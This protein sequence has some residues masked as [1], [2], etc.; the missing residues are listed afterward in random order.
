MDSAEFKQ[1][2]LP[3]HPLFFRIARNMLE[4]PDDAADAVQELYLRLCREEERLSRC[5]NPEGYGIRILQHLCTDR[6]RARKRQPQSLEA[7][8]QVGRIPEAA[9]PDGLS[10]SISRETLARL[11]QCI[12]ELPPRQRTVLILRDLE[13]MEMERISEITGLTGGNLRV[14]LFRA[15]QTVRKRLKMYEND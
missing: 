3:L 5:S 7:G 15:R 11:R 14:L 4:N 12:R 2:W 8:M 13:E 1:R 6:L 10:A 9:G